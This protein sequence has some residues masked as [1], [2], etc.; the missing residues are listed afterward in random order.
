MNLIFVPA[1][2][3]FSCFP[4]CSSTVSAPQVLPSIIEISV[5]TTAGFAAGSATTIFPN[6]NN[7]CHSVVFDLTPLVDQVGVRSAVVIFPFAFSVT[8]FEKSW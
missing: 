4:P 7:E 8:S 5:P 6:L 2:V 3:T 1:A